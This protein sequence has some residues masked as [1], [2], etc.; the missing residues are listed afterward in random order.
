MS[1]NVNSMELIELKNDLNVIG[2]ELEKFPNGISEL[3]DEL[4][5][6]VPEGFNR[7]FYGLSHMGKDGGMVYRAAAEA[8]NNNEWQILNLNQ[9]VI[10]KGKYLSIPVLDW[11]KN[12]QKINE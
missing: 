3:F 6:R 11:R 7:S 5:N 4:I 12:L 8:R 1:H 2:L 10:E 9:Y